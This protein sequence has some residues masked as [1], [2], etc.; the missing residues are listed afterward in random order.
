MNRGARQATVHRIA[1]V[2]H[3]LALSFFLSL[4][5]GEWTLEEGACPFRSAITPLVVHEWF[6]FLPFPPSIIKCNIWL[7]KWCQNSTVITKTYQIKRENTTKNKTLLEHSIIGI[8]NNFFFSIPYEKTRFS[9][10]ILSKTTYWKM[11]N[12]TNY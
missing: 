5:K 7:W 2:G 12:I 1:R 3:D 4:L 9:F 10:V 8:S 6:W 11:L